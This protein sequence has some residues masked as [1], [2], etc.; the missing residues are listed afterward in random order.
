M[1]LIVY[2]N[3]VV[4]NQNNLVLRFFMDG[5]QG[6]FDF[7]AAIIMLIAEPKNTFEQ[8]RYSARL[9]LRARASL[10]CL[11]S[12]SL[13]EWDGGTLSGSAATGDFCR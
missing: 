1:R 7:I 11:A 3:L 6:H 13:S 5:Q 8:T 9:R 12:F 10:L 2:H 4:S